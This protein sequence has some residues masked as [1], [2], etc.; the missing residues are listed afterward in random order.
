MKIIERLGDASTTWYRISTSPTAFFADQ[1]SLLGRLQEL[2]TE[3]DA[4]LA[5][6]FE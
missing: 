3:L 5:L 6:A 4:E 2:E 1:P